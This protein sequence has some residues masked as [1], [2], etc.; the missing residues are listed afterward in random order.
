MRK[1]NQP[2]CACPCCCT[3]FQSGFLYDPGTNKYLRDME[4][5]ISG[6]TG[7]AGG[8][9][10]GVNGTFLLAGPHTPDAGT[11]CFN[12]TLNLS[13]VCS[14]SPNV[15]RVILQIGGS[16]GGISPGPYFHVR[17][18]ED[19]LEDAEYGVNGTTACRLI[20]RVMSGQLVT[21]PIFNTPAACG[22]S[23]ATVKVRFA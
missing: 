11:C 22:A 15:R 17:V 2:G 9:C 1:R 3:A 12:T 7:G 13:P 20:G 5:Q 8:C 4:V 23:G 6:W 21:L 14:S 18:A 10:S 19:F 16:C